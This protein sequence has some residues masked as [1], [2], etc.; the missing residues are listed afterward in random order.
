MCSSDLICP[1]RSVEDQNAV[2]RLSTSHTRFWAEIEPADPR[3]LRK[4]GPRASRCTNDQRHQSTWGKYMPDS[5]LF[6]GQNAVFRLPTSHT[7]FLAEIRTVDPHVLRKPGLRA[8]RFTNNQRHRSPWE[9][10]MLDPV[11][12]ESQNAVFQ[13]L[14]S[15]T[16]F[17]A[18]IRPVDLHVLGKP[19]LRA[20]RCTNDQRHQSTWG[21]MMCK[22][23]INNRK[24]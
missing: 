2:F 7:G 8:A 6:E 13:L 3:M 14:T 22:M 4:P 15:H 18:G 21:E 11:T 24:S 16:G 1:I 12:V 9:E 10:Y 17:L 19:G 23:F 20:A 5:V